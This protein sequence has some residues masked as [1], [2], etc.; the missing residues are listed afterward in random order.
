MTETAKLGDTAFEAEVLAIT[1]ELMQSGE[2][3]E[4]FRNK[5]RAGFEK[6][7]EDSFRW[8]DLNHAIAAATPSCAPSRKL[9][10]LNASSAKRPK[11]AFRP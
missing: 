1:Q 4:I 9:A 8:G 3:E 6:A 5:I 7:I 10:G 11:K 2:I